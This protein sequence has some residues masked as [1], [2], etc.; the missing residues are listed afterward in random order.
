MVLPPDVQPGY[1]IEIRFPKRDSKRKIHA[2]HVQEWS[3]DPDPVGRIVSE[4]GWL[5]DRLA[6][7][8]RRVTV[9]MNYGTKAVSVG[10]IVL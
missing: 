6:M 2:I 8:A 4:Y 7:Q 9:R 3:D 1:E 10:G 5:L